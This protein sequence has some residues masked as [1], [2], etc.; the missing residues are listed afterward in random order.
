MIKRIVFIVCV[1]LKITVLHSQ[2]KMPISILSNG[3]TR[4]VEGSLLLNA[5]FCQTSIGVTQMLPSVNY[6]GFWYS[7]Y[8]LVNPITEV[9]E[10]NSTKSSSK[11][12]NFKNYPNPVTSNTT[13]EFNIPLD[14]YVSLKLFNSIGYEVSTL[15]DGNRSL[16][17]IKVHLSSNELKSGKYFAVLNTSGKSERISFVVIN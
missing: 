5:T 15:I 1:M 9:V 4:S 7:A 12:L 11:E 17:V 13:I 10:E 8:N 6:Q 2:T 3:A 14:S 16:G